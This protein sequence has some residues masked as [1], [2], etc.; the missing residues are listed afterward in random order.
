MDCREME[1][2]I[3]IYIITIFSY[4]TYRGIRAHQM[5]HNDEVKVDLSIFYSNRKSIQTENRREQKISLK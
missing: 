5:Y 3:Y 4:L 1:C 2:L